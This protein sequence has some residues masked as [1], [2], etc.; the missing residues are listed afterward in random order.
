MLMAGQSTDTDIFCLKSIKN[1]SEDPFNYLQSWNF[2][3]KTEGF[4]CSFNGVE[5]WHPDE[6]RVLN[7]KLFNIGL[8][9]QFPRALR[10]CSSLMDLDFSFNEPSGPIPY[11]ISRIVTFIVRLDLSNKTFTGEIP[12]SLANCTYLNVLKLNN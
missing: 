3:N 8:K 7:P 2:N 12:K 9:G 11:D 1:S 5:C 4:I 6:S 10:N